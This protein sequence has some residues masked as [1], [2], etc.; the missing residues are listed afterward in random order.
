MSVGLKLEHIE[1]PGAVI[2]VEA[3]IDEIVSVAIVLLSS[4]RIGQ[5]HLLAA[6]FREW[7]R[8]SALP[9]VSGV[10]DDD[11]IAPAALFRPGV[12]DEAV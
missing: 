11:K 9:L 3:A 7:Q 6:K 12:G 8:Q 5:S 10:V 1:A 4:H 2:D